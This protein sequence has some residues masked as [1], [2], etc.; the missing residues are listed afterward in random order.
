MNKKK[1]FLLFLAGAAIGF[2]NGFFGGGGGMLA[3]PAL[4]ALAVKDEKKARATA[5]AVIL[6]LS[7]VSGIVYL[8]KGAA[9]IPLLLAT[10]GGVLVGGAAGALLL[11]K[12]PNEKLALFFY[13]LMIASGI[14]N[15]II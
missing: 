14:Y 12:M 13:V 15:L 2:A 8:M 4:S 6:P 3:V 10:G 11:K 9:E 7:A 5:I 1:K